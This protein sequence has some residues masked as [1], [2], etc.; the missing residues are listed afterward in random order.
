[1]LE[2]GNTKSEIYIGNNID[3]DTKSSQ[4]RVTTVKRTNKR[5][6]ELTINRSQK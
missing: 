3:F 2:A 5:L 4:V 1:M 6:K